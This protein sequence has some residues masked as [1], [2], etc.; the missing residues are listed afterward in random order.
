MLQ[1]ANDQIT[2]RLGKL[3]FEVRRASKAR[4]AEAIHD[5]RVAI[6]RFAQSLIV[7]GSLVPKRDAAK[8]RKRLGR[9]MDDAG[10]IRDRDIAIEFLGEAGVPA[11]HPLRRR[12]AAERAAAEKDLVDRIKRW[13]QKNVS[14]KWRAALRLDVS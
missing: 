12:L 2:A 11:E 10:R 9:M 4:D 7:F 3:A 5:L 8:I 14:G 1:F 6:R 13:N